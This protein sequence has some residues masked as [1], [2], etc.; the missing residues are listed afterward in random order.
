MNVT[1]TEEQTMLQDSV[2]KFVENE[3]PLEKVRE[4]FDEP[5]GLTAE[6][7][8]KIAEQGW[9]GILV[10]EEY[11]G[12]GMGAQELAVVCEELGRGAVPGPFRS[13]I[14]AAHLIALGGTD[15]AKQAWLEGIVAGESRATL[16]LIE[17]TPEIDLSRIET[18]AVSLNGGYLLNGKKML[19]ADA[20]GADLFVVAARKDDGSL[21]FFLVE[22]G[23]GGVT[24]KANKLRDL[25]AHSGNLYLENATVETDAI[26]DQDAENAYGKTLNIANV[27]IAADSIAGAEYIHKMTV[28]YAK[29]RTQFG[30]YIGSFQ[31]VK[32]PLVDVFAEI[33]SAKSAYYYAA[34]AIDADSPDVNAAVAVARNTCTQAYRDTTAVC[35]Q[36]H[37]GIAF[38]WEYD[39]HIF[40]K[41]AKHNQFL[42]GSSSESDEV[43]CKEAL[44]I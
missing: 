34:W 20:M 18:T 11:G 4:L 38:T 7:W 41:R 27:C 26:I 17:E 8:T 35:L 14:L 24:V 9:L 16:A 29:E 36:A 31:A 33:E 37:G 2:K 10:P 44:G 1:I 3:I 42:Y 13:T 6:L 21:A 25:T 28:A 39:L 19:V 23:A 40:L 15:T 22:R 32:H 5:N 43:I 12:L 30:K